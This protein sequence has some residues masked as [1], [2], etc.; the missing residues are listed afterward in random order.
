MAFADPNWDGEEL[1]WS[2]RGVTNKQASDDPLRDFPLDSFR[3]EFMGRNL[4]MKQQ[5]QIWN[6]A[7]RYDTRGQG[8][9]PLLTGLVTLKITVDLQS[10]LPKSCDFFLIFLL[11]VAPN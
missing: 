3:A 2:V 11:K 6:V 7:L 8:L 5:G 10:S 4:W 1:V 9:C